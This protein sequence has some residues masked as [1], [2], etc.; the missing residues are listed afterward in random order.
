MSISTPDFCD[1][2]SEEVRVLAPLFRNFGGRL[3]F[4]GRVR[5]VKCFEDNSRVKEILSTPGQ[6]QV[7]FVDGG[8]S[9]RC[10]L[11]GDLIA[12]SAVELGWSGVIIWGAV[13]DVDALATLELGVQ[14]VAAFPLKSVRRGVGDVDVPLHVA[15]QFIQPGDFIYA[16]NNGVIISSKSLV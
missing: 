11:M 7:L 2:H 8:G 4:G 16:D 9:L 5:T 13:R 3:A 14:A 12:S 1:A 10:A 6:G 15:G